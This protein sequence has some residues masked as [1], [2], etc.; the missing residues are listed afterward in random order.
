MTTQ[1]GVLLDL[2]DAVQTN[3]ETICTL[4]INIQVPK[5]I[6]MNLSV[7]KL[8]IIE[9]KI[10]LSKHLADRFTMIESTSMDNSAD[11]DS[12][13]S[14]QQIPELPI[15]PDDIKN[16]DFILDSKEDSKAD[17]TNDLEPSML[18]EESSINDLL[19]SSEVFCEY[20]FKNNSQ[21][22]SVSAP[23]ERDNMIMEVM[24]DE[25]ETNHD[26][27]D[28]NDDDMDDIK[29]DNSSEDEMSDDSE[30]SGKNRIKGISILFFHFHM[31]QQ[32][33]LSFHQTR[34]VTT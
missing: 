31:V 34:C 33:Q 20:E 2:V 6:I 29:S 21:A 22:A 27:P 30:N 13:I 5:E 3:M 23:D 9:S 1:M 16:E 10:Y 26:D 24:E 4:A 14:L 19:Q 12:N 28:Y 11:K 8:T 7:A 25:N 32:F 17:I 15:D 18:L